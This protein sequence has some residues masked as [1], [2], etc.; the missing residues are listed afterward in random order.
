[1]KQLATLAAAA[2][3]SSASWATAI[4]DISAT[5]TGDIR[6]DNPDNIAVD[7]FGSQ[8]ATG[9]VFNFSV[10][11]NASMATDHPTARLQ[12]VAFNLDPILSSNWDVS[13]TGASV[14]AWDV[15]GDSKNPGAGT[16][17]LT[18][19]W[20]LSDEPGP[21]VLPLT[22]DLTKLVADSYGADIHGENFWDADFATSD[23]GIFQVSAKVGGLTLNG[24]AT[25][26][27]GTAVGCWAGG[28]DCGGPDPQSVSAPGTI[29]LLSMGLVGLVVA[30]R[31]KK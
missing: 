18:F 2:V 26:D 4:T 19:T 24:G 22:F 12:Q 10:D 30:R 31:Q 16:G 6:A 21:D 5:L 25:S 15:T 28:A 11:F 7:V 8:G 9:D 20:L 27:S 23:A 17:A 29:A 3:L 1:M 13:L 14:G